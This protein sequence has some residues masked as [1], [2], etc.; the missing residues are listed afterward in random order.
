TAERTIRTADRP[1]LM[2]NGVPTGFYRRVLAAS[3]LSAYSETTIRNAESLGLLDRLNV[4][5]LHVFSAP[6]TALMTRA[7]LSDDE[8][9]S[10]IAGERR[11]AKEE[12]TSFMDRI[13]VNGMS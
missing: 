1:V 9:Q 3:D 12:V 2:A 5:L 7:S 4:S 8:I 13:K 10:Y 11:R 6:G